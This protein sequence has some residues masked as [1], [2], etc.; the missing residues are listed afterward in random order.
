MDTRLRSTKLLRKINCLLVKVYTKQFIRGLIQL[1]YI[2]LF[3][4]LL[5][6]KTFFHLLAIK[7][8][9]KDILFK[10]LVLTFNKE[11]TIVNLSTF[12]LHNLHSKVKL[13]E[14]IK[15]QNS[16]ALNLKNLFFTKLLLNIFLNRGCKE[17]TLKKK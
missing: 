7:E 5:K 13:I 10:H 14:C 2:K 12:S 11:E 3:K 8:E 4:K 1:L 17:N 15:Y 6:E 9:E 16:K